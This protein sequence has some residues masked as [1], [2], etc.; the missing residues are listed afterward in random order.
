MIIHRVFLDD[1]DRLK[2]Y[3]NQACEI[4]DNKSTSDDKKVTCKN[5]IQI[6]R[7]RDKK[8]KK[9]EGLR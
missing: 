5:C 1:D 9:Q 2:Y 6:I 8:L 3:C 7:N 4:T